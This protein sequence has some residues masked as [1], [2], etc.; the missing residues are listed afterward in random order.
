MAVFPL[1]P[2][3]FDVG[4]DVSLS[5]ESVQSRCEVGDSEISGH[6]HFGSD[7]FGIP[8]DV[9][10]KADD[11][12][13]VEALIAAH[14]PVK[15]DPVSFDLLILCQ[16]DSDHRLTLGSHLKHI[17]RKSPMNIPSLTSTLAMHLSHCSH[18]LTI[19]SSSSVNLTRIPPG[20]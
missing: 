4:P 8:C 20:L 17:H 10:V 16:Y 19:C 11:L 1:R 14:R 7:S 13:C 12:L 2:L 15:A 5:L 18:R 6:S 3:H 9:F